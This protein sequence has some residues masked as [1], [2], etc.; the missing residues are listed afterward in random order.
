MDFT[1]N[2]NDLPP[3]KRIRLIHQQQQQSSLLPTK[4]RKES[5]NTS[6]FHN[7]PST[8]SPSIYSLPT[9]KRVCALQPHDV[10]PRIDLNVEYNPALH[11]PTPTEKQTPKQDTNNDQDAADD[12]G[13]LCCVCQSTNANFEDPPLRLEKQW[14]EDPI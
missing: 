12:D 4:K 8:P 10:A 13:I 3:N 11:S 1:T 2:L 14:E 5:R 7:P 6:L 9:K